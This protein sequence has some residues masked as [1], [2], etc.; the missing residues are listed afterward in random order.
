MSVVEA[1]PV[2]RGVNKHQSGTF[3][4]TSQTVP[5]NG[6]LIVSV[7]LAHTQFLMGNM[8]LHLPNTI[9]SQSR[10][11]ISAVIAFS[12]DVNESHSAAGRLINYTITGYNG[13]P[14]FFNDWRQEG[15]RFDQ[16]GR[17]STNTWDGGGSAGSVQISSVRINGANVELAFFNPHPSINEVVS[18][19]G[20]YQVYG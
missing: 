19:I 6:T 1:Q 3:E 12:T 14:Y 5:A 8:I 16:D 13:I 17:L 9:A 10:R 20:S 18:V 15:Y 2:G 11:R 7:P 4:V